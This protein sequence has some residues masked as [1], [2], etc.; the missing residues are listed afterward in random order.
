MSDQSTDVTEER[1]DVQQDDAGSTEAE[2]ARIE[3]LENAPR[4]SSAQA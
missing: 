4:L 2:S 1:D 3:R